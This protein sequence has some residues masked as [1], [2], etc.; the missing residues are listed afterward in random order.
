M[1]KLN[2]PCELHKQDVIP[3]VSIIVVNWNGRTLLND[4]LDS[5]FRQAYSQREIILVDNGSIDN[6]V[7]WVRKNFPQIRLIQLSNNKGFTGGNL[8]GLEVAR[9]EFIALVNNDTRAETNWLERLLAPMLNDRTIGLCASKLVIESSGRID[10]AG[11]GLT[12]AGV[13]FNRG[14]RDDHT[15][16]SSLEPVFAA[17]GV[18]CLCRSCFV[19]PG[20]DQ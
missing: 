14:H 10:S 8:A 11:D 13:G 6:S 7:D 20:D 2:E 9:G 16:Y 19:S 18:C 12:S 15:N 4:C 3:R 1:A 17:C 5:L